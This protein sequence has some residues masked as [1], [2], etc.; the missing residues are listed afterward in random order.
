MSRVQAFRSLQGLCS[1]QMRQQG[2]GLAAIGMQHARCDGFGVAALSRLSMAGTSGGLSH[3]ACPH[4]THIGSTRACQSFG[5]ASPPT[6]QAPT[7]S[8][9]QRII[10][11]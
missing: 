5:A 11:T 9:P 1:A 7:S 10:W 8:E 3:P 6:T 2:Q 4:A